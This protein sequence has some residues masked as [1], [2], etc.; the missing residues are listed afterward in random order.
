MFALIVTMGVISYIS[1]QNLQSKISHLTEKSTPSVIESS[2]LLSSV[3]DARLAVAAA[4]GTEGI[5]TAKQDIQNNRTAFDSALI[6]LENL[7]MGDRNT[8]VRIDEIK[9]DA[10]SFYS[11]TLE[12]LEDKA[13]LRNQQDRLS[14]LNEQFIRLDDTY[15]WASNLLLQKAAVKRSLQNRAE[16]ISSGI[17]RD[18][19]NLRRA[20]A[21]T[22]LVALKTTLEKD[23][24]IALKRLALIDVNSEVKARFERNVL[25]LKELT[26]EKGGL[27]ETLNHRNR[28]LEK[29]TGSEQQLAQ[30]QNELRGKI[31]QLAFDEKSKADSSQ[32]DASQASKSA[33][34]LNF[35]MT[36]ASGV[37]AVIVAYSSAQAIRKP[38]RQIKSVLDK[39]SQGDMSQRTG[40]DAADE[41]GEIARNIDVL[42]SSMSHTLTNINAGSCHL[43]EEAKESAI[44]SEMAMRRVE[45]QKSRTDQVAAAISEME[46]SA[47]E[48]NR[49]TE[50]TV[51]EVEEANTRSCAGREQVALNRAIT[52]ELANH[53]S[54]AVGSSEELNKL[55][56]QIGTIL[57]VIREIADQTNLLALN[58]AIE[59]ARAG[60]MGRGFAVVADEVRALATR[61]Q[62]STEE[63]HQ[64]IEKLQRHTES[65]VNSMALSEEKTISCVE[66]SR[67]TDETLQ[68]IAD[69]VSQIREMAAQVSN[70]T[71]EQIKVCRDVAEHINGIAEVA[72]A[73]E[74]EARESSQRSE[75]LTQ[76]ASEQQSQ[77][78]K[79]KV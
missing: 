65:L 25:K 24:D 48:I 53:I 78:S 70:A 77:I 73:A 49:S 63:I 50:R 44:S 38:F 68:E 75:T 22:N 6:N 3:I 31:D 52:E 30:L 18:L 55:T 4:T 66:Q 47:Q 17:R 79:F 7:N 39:M 69:S 12:L 33:L 40:Y 43:L 62:Q 10:F 56:G 64:M 20:N 11:K 19:N 13:A 35:I 27:I 21:D 9:K 37:V 72:H 45:D 1:T 8:L 61:T 59:A 34:I 42:I 54:S 28:I 67:L 41:F 76:L 51:N 29:I 46:V 14:T 36:L 23:I 57:G 32:R 15:Q 5:R 16:L 58:A 26:L 74:T 2:H 71:E 60:D